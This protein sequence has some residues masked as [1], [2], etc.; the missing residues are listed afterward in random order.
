MGVVKYCDS[1]GSIGEV[2]RTYIFL[3]NTGGATVYQRAIGSLCEKCLEKFANSF[4]VEHTSV[5][6][7]QKCR[8]V[9]GTY[10][11]Y[12]IIRPPNSKSYQH[13]K[14]IGLICKKCVDDLIVDNKKLRKVYVIINVHTL[15]A[16]VFEDKE[17]AERVVRE[18]NN[19]EYLRMIECVV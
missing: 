4:S 18:S 1:C 15:E 6:A 16:K 19:P 13:Y 8:S 12:V 14:S 10:R 11:G 7:C 3:H 9:E 5:R 2:Y 17:T